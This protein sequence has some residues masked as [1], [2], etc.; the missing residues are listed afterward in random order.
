M[1]LFYRVNKIKE[2][3]PLPASGKVSTARKILGLPAAQDF[4][5]Y[6]IDY[7]TRK[8]V[9]QRYVS[10][11]RG[12]RLHLKH[13]CAFPEQYPVPGAQCPMQDGLVSKQAQ[14]DFSYCFQYRLNSAVT[15]IGAFLFGASIA[16]LI[17]MGR[18]IPKLL[19]FGLVVLSHGAGRL[20][21]L[22]KIPSK[23][24]DYSLAAYFAAGCFVIG[25]AF[26]TSPFDPNLW[27]YGLAPLALGVSMFI[28][29]LK[30]FQTNGEFQETSSPEK[31][32]ECK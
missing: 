5:G 31:N 18:T 26:L 25:G 20:L 29:G 22:P 30:I 15:G 14:L 32:S 7:Q 6:L 9:A 13:F 27:N 12:S 11:F 1:R 16:P 21:S 24:L 2:I 10:N 4:E 3:R 8:G 17:S 28:Y 23:A 19:L